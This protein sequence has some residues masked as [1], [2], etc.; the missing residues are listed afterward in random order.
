MRNKHRYSWLAQV[1]A[2]QHGKH[3]GTFQYTSD[4]QVIQIL[5]MFS[6]RGNIRQNS[7][8]PCFRL[9]SPINTQI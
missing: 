4:D 9:Q 3:T 2:E 7:L 8:S 6:Q 5:I 1:L